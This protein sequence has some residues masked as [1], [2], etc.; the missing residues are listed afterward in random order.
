MTA[1]VKPGQSLP[2]ETQATA[3]QQQYLTFQLG[4]E[5][6]A[7][8]ILCV[9]EIIE[10]GDLTVVPMMPESIRGV[11]NLRGAVVPVIDLS[12]RFGRQP[13]QLT[14]RTCIIIVEIVNDDERQEVG[15][16]VDAVS[17]VLEIREDQI[18]PPPAFGAKIR[19]DFIRGMGKV[20][21]KF[22]IIL[23]VNRVLSLDDLAMVGQMAATGA[24]TDALEHALD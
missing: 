21:G 6:F 14:R 11:I 4:A 12:S 2:Q 8:G 18:E 20:D 24:E 16:I 13:T 23:N 3:E 5:M 19:T 1:L 7:T 9:K 17:E 15:V 10:Y 22:V